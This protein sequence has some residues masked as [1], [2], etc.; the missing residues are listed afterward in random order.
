LRANGP[1]TT[2]EIWEAGFQE[3]LYERTLRRA[4]K[5][6]NVTADVAWVNGRRQCYWLLPGQVLPADGRDEKD[7]AGAQQFEEFLANYRK[8]YCTRTPL[9]NAE[10]GELERS[11]P[12]AEQARTSV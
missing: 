10:D 2:A 11:P 1:R 3:Q 5:D 9:D 12:A 4:C 7:L 6:A 8:T